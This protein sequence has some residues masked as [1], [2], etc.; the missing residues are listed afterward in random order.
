[1]G[2]VRKRPSHGA[3]AQPPM[4]PTGPAPDAAAA[5]KAPGSQ[6]GPV[7]GLQMPPAS[8][9]LRCPSSRLHREAGTACQA[10]VPSLPPLHRS[11]P[12]SPGSPR[13]CCLPGPTSALRTVSRA[14]EEFPLPS[15]ARPAVA[16]APCWGPRRENS[17]T[18]SAEACYL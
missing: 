3:A 18:S 8:F 6:Q 5:N 16:E 11:S 9:P 2:G 15:K 12:D 4:P 1:M 7:P 17:L 13:H 14:P 10:G